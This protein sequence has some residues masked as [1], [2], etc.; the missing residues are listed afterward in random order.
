MIHQDLDDVINLI[1]QIY[2]AFVMLYFG[3]IFSAFN[4]F[5]FSLVI[6]KNYYEDPTEALIMLITNSEWNLYDIVIIFVI[7][8]STTSA[9][10]EGRNSLSFIYKTVNTSTD[11]KL[12]ERVSGIAFFSEIIVS[13]SFCSPS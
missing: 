10:N 8:S 7:I 6:L 9:T 12:N 11:G 4:L 13:V 1:N 2:S 3:G 5:L